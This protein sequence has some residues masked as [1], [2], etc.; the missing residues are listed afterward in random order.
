MLHC[1]RPGDVA[2][3]CA[4]P[5]NAKALRDLERRVEIA[6]AEVVSLLWSGA[7]EILA[8]R[9]AQEVLQEYTSKTGR[10]ITS[11]TPE[12]V[13]ERLEAID[14]RFGRDTARGLIFGILIYRHASEIAHGTL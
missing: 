11:W 6:G 8:S 5:H 1:D 3:S 9:A 10:E 4:A 14:R 7:D 13:K 2:R 12:T